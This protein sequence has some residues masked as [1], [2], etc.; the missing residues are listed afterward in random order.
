MSYCFCIRVVKPPVLISAISHRNRLVRIV[1]F[2]SKSGQKASVEASKQRG[3]N[4]KLK[5]CFIFNFCFSSINVYFVL[6]LLYYFQLC[7]FQLI[8]MSSLKRRPLFCRTLLNILGLFSFDSCK[9]RILA[10][11]SSSGS[12]EVS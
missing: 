7:Y 5:A 1:A 2:L 8:H 9:A 4:C 11:G 3:L 6:H 10:I 12:T